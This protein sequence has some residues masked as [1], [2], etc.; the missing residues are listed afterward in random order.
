MNDISSL[1]S[2]VYKGANLKQLEINDIVFDRLNHELSIIEKLNLVDYFLIYSKIVEICNDRKLLRSYG[3]SSSCGSLVNYCL[4]ISKINPLMEGLI[5]ERFLNPD[6]SIFADID[7]DIP[8][9]HQETIIEQL[10]R[11][12]PDH[13]ILHLAFLPATSC[14]SYET[15]IINDLSYKRHPCRIIISPERIS[16]PIGEYNG[17][18]YY[19]TNDYKNFYKNFPSVE[20]FTFDI[21]ESE[22]LNKLE[23]IVQI[24]GDEYHPYKLPMSDK[25][26]FEFFNNGDLSNIFQFDTNSMGKILHDFK[27]SSINELAMINALYRPRSL[28]LIKSLIYHKRNGYVDMYQNDRRVDEILKETYGLLVYQETFMM[29]LNVISGFSYTEA[30][31]YRRIIIW[32]DDVQ[33]IEEF[34]I[35]FQKGS[36]I[37]STL[38]DEEIIRLETMI[39][40]TLPISFIKS[41]SLCYTM[42][43][44]WG[45]YYK[46]NFENAF[47]AVFTI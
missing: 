19:Y 35:K 18:E 26:V 5:F 47:N 30:D 25:R 3:R 27:A 39:L 38:N 20:N 1:K 29:L 41:H 8:E 33:K 37:H 44:Y 31:I 11:E 34:R 15:I 4:D 13:I 16:L 23:Q 6:I 40:E 21:L 28:Q 10:R 14:E 43:A 45:A 17:R 12:L 42:I 24:I 22:Y 7:I 36:R 32:G 46:V 9:G 2:L